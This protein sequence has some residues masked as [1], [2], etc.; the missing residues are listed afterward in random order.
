MSK[1]HAPVEGLTTHDPNSVLSVLVRATAFPSPSTTLRPVVQ[2]EKAQAR[3]HNRT[4]QPCGGAWHDQTLSP[5]LLHSTQDAHACPH[6]HAWPAATVF[7]TRCS[8]RR[9]LVTHKTRTHAHTRA[10]GLHPLSSGS[11]RRRAH[12]HQPPRAV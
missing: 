7:R 2:Q 1:V 9:F 11:G 10:H 12:D 6:A 3:E 5:P 4:P 8:A